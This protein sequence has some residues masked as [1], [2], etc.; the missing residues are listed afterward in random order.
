MG[1]DPRISL[2]SE[3]LRTSKRTRVLALSA[4]PVICASVRRGFCACDSQGLDDMRHG[5]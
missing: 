3:V 2:L 5:L 4:A 1:H